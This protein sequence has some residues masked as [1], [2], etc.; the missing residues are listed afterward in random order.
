[1][2]E[3][4]AL[5][6]HKPGARDARD[7]VAV[8]MGSR[9]ACASRR[10]RRERWRRRSGPRW[11]RTC[12]RKRSSPPG[13]TTRRSSTS[14][15]VTFGTLHSA[16]DVTAAS[17]APSASGSRSATGNQQTH[18]GRTCAA[19]GLF[20]GGTPAPVGLDGHDAHDSGRVVRE[21]GAGAGADLH[22]A[23]AQSAHEPAPLG[24]THR[25][26]SPAEGTRGR[27][28][29]PAFGTRRRGSTTCRARARPRRLRRRRSA[30]AGGQ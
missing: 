13:R 27:R 21:R 24:M 23:P 17:T 16:S 28:A 26:S 9:P 5:L 14:A 10:G 6:D 1:M 15:S 4:I 8:D 20:G 7:R 22:D 18:M 25:L 2:H 12:S 3:S 19:G 29:P 30:R 11:A